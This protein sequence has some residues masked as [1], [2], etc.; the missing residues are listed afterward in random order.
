MV[1]EGSEKYNSHIKIVWFMGITMI[2]MSLFAFKEYYH[3]SLN[4]VSKLIMVQAKS[5]GHDHGN[6]AFIL[7][8]GYQLKID[9]NENGHKRGLHIAILNHANGKV[10]TSKAFDT[11][12]SSETLEKFIGENPVADGNMVIAVCYDECSTNLSTKAK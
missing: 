7:V 3:K 1:V 11:F 8:H 9:K 2:T 10:I 6:K 12:K 4:D 5:A